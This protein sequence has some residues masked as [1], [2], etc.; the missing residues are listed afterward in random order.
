M[1]ESIA[2]EWSAFTVPVD[3]RFFDDYRPGIS[4]RYGH[5]LVTESDVLRFAREFDPQTIHTDPSAAASGPFA[6]LIASGWHTTAI[7]MRVF[8]TQFLNDAAS[9]AS[10]G[11]DELRWLR[12]VRP[13]DTLAVRFTIVSA[14]VSTSKPDRGIVHTNVEMLNQDD[15]PVLTMT[16]MNMLRRRQ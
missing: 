9:L 6:G 16:A 15:E 11:V 13:G 5:E 4:V 12:P 10:P 3:D 7:M 1:E 8:A 2:T 14:R